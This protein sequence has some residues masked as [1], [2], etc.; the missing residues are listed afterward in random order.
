MKKI[1]CIVAIFLL[2]CFNSNLLFGKKRSSVAY[3]NKSGTLI[4]NKAIAI[5]KGKMC[6][7]I[8]PIY[9]NSLPGWDVFKRE[10]KAYYGSLIEPDRELWGGGFFLSS[11]DTVITSHLLVASAIYELVNVLPPGI[12][13]IIVDCNNFQNAQG[14]YDES[15]LR[16]QLNPDVIV[17]LQ[18]LIFPVKGDLNVNSV[19]EKTTQGADSYSIG[20]VSYYSGDIF[21]AYR[22]LWKIVWKDGQIKEIEQGGLRQSKYRK[23]YDFIKDLFSFSKETGRDFANLLTR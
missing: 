8:E 7:L 23:D 10:S 1:H 20:A 9:D 3:D 16:E 19:V 17:T 5:P 21:I 6:I 4:E 11:A 14:V 12:E 2:M 22:A 13:Y 15:L 18:D